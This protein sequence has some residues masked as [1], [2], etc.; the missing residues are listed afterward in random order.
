MDALFLLV[1][2]VMHDHSMFEGLT[3]RAD[4]SDGGATPMIRGSNTPTLHRSRGSP[5][6]RWGGRG[7]R[8]CGF[9]DGLS[10]DGGAGAVGRASAWACGC[11]RRCRAR[12][13][14]LRSRR[15]AN[16]CCSLRHGHRLTVRGASGRSCRLG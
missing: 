1:S 3:L 14:H 9:R 6:G 4:A 7:G 15:P 2:D 11:R 12:R 16:G 13:S 8:G 5:C 10:S